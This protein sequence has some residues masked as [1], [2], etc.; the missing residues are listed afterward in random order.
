MSHEI[1]QLVQELLDSSKSD[2]L[3]TIEATAERLSVSTRTVYRLVADGKLGPVKVRGCTRLRESSVAALSG[4]DAEEVD[5]DS[6][7]QSVSQ[8]VSV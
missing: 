1:R 5:T 4:S 6:E 2:R 8:P 3:L 7:A